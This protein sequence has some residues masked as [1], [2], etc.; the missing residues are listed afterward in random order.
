LII[1]AGQGQIV[2]FGLSSGESRQLP[3]AKPAAEQRSRSDTFK[4]SGVLLGTINID[5]FMTCIFFGNRAKM[6]TFGSFKN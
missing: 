5:V 4:L 1:S 6:A 3:E 2:L